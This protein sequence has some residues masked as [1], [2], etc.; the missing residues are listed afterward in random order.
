MPGASFSTSEALARGTSA[1]CETRIW[2]SEVP[3][4]GGGRRPMTFT[5]S[6]ATFG[7]GAGTASAGGAAGD[8]G[9]GTA[10]GGGAAGAGAG[11]AGGSK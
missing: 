3:R 10:T 9:T 7:A 6:A 11:C 8:A 2:K 4:L 1:S 5:S